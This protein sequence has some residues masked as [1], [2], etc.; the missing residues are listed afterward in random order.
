MFADQENHENVMLNVP[1]PKQR[2]YF[3][4]ISC[5]VIMY[6]GK[7]VNIKAHKYISIQSC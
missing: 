5:C 4:K 1:R 3:V 2:M 6:G 7:I